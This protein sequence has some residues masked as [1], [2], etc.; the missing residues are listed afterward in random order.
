MVPL[1]S[2][3]LAFRATGA[4]RRIGRQPFFLN[5]TDLIHNMRNSTGRKASFLESF[6]AGAH[7]E[8]TK[9]RLIIVFFWVGNSADRLKRERI[10]IDRFHP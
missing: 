10:K 5:G 1:F 7:Q 3:H 9:K 4:I 6:T 8:I 2:L